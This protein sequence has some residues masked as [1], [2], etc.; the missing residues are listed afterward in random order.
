MTSTAPSPQDAFVHGRLINLVRTGQAVTRPALEQESGLGRK[1]VAQRVQQAIDAGLLEDGDLAPSGGGRPSRQLRFRAEAGHVYA[2]MIAS[3]EC[4]AAVATLD[5]TVLASLH[6]DWDAGSGP[7]A[8]LEMLDGLFT[9]LSRRTRTEP[10]AFGIGISGPVHFGSGR[11]VDPPILPGWDGYSPRAWLRDRYDAPVWV[12][13]DVNLMALA[14][15]HLGTPQDGR[16]LLYIL[17]DEGVGAGLVSRGRVWRGDTG[18]AGDIGHL[19]V[20]DDPGV[21]CR[22]GQTG[23]LEALTGG[24]SLV[25]RVTGR[26]AE[27][28]GLTRLLERHGQLSAEDV[29]MAARGGDPLAVEVVLGSARL[30]GQT[31]ANLVNFVNPGTVVLGGGALRVGDAVPQTFEDAVRAGVSRLAGQQLTVRR[32]SLAFQEGVAGAAILAIEQ[33]FSPASI[34][35]W[36]DHGSPVGRAAHLQQVT[37]S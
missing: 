25:H 37:A 32:A 30:V 3:T 2:G 34:G 4:R 19:R 15:W 28:P 22:C 12:D 29:G 23:C 1:L 17:V 9:R 6:Q 35:A 27:S 21:V 13:N 26:V 18:A 33:L 14:E 16:D 11:V 5:G 36:L 31:V 20:T 10:W 24:W 7:E 8:T